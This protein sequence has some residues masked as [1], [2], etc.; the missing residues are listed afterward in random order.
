MDV[1][2]YILPFYRQSSRV[3][4]LKKNS[5]CQ[6]HTHWMYKTSSP[7]Y[8]VSFHS[9]K[10]QVNAKGSTVSLATLFSKFNT[11]WKQLRISL[12]VQLDKVLSHTWV[13]NDLHC[14]TFRTSLSIFICTREV[15]TRGSVTIQH[16][17][18]RQV[19]FSSFLFQKCLNI[20]CSYNKFLYQ[21]LEFCTSQNHSLYL[22]IHDHLP[23]N[24]AVSCEGLSVLPLPFVVFF[25]QSFQFWECPNTFCS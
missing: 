14:Y 16:L 20:S 1:L 5:I 2:K 6:P 4:N 17:Y 23:T 19:S 22:H 10:S 24:F 12:R 7:T 13:F 9:H 25:F 11:P 8:R 18:P 15:F 3:H 21:I